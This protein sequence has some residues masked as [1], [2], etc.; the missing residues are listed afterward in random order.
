V[1]PSSPQ[2][3]LASGAPPAWQPG[4]EVLAPAKVNL[5][6]RVVGRR[7]DG[8]HFL[9]SIV[10]AVTL[11][12]RLVVEAFDEQPAASE[13][14]VSVVTDRA[15][16]PDGRENVAWRAARGF[17]QRA[18][19][20]FRLRLRIEKRIPAGAGLGGGSSDAA[21][22]LDGLNRSFG[23][24]LDGAQLVDLAAAV[25][26]DVP[27][28]LGPSP[29]LVTGIGERLQPYAGPVPEHLVLCGD[30]ASLAT[31]AVFAGYDAALTSSGRQSTVANPPDTDGAPAVFFNDLESAAIALHPGVLLA[32]QEL[33]RRGAR[34]ALMTGSGAVVYG[35][36]EG[37]AEAGRIASE[38]REAG[39]W[40]VAVRSIVRPG[41]A[42]R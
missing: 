4:L 26:A 34:T 29:A 17:A 22:V 19:R 1:A 32:K 9:E 35:V 18:R 21:C 25:G 39:Y 13:P 8:Y 30:G 6:L 41:D 12:D 42:G 10:V 40:S 38:L 27:F 24:P 11:Y 15:D 2:P 28:F 31:A 20:S 16:V 37:R 7:P 14:D 23:Q 33:R 3:H 5:H 36:V